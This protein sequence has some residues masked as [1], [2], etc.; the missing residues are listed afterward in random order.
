MT[1]YGR[2]RRIETREVR[3][4]TVEGADY[5]AGYAALAAQ[6]GEGEQLILVSL[7]PVGG[8]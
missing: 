8:D 7:W 2:I 4:A 6:V 1:V 3:S 5:A